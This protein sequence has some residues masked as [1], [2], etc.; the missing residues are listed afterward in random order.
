MNKTIY[1]RDE[2]TPIWDRAKELAGEKLAP[3]IVDG[4]R[5][6]IADREAKDAEQKGY[7]RIELEFADAEFGGLL[8]RKAFHGRWIFSP[9]APDKIPDENILYFGAVAV[10]PKGSVVVYA[11]EEEE[12]RSR[13]SYISFVVFTSFEEGASNEEYGWV[14][15]SAR[16]KD[17]APLEELDI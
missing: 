1:I 5:K 16:A 9:A 12:A 4:L 8:R 15:R 11:W 3:V 14:V 7:E 2:D 10:T 13:R 6:F 17:G